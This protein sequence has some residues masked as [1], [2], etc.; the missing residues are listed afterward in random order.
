MKNIYPILIIFLCFVFLFNGK[1]YDDL[2]SSRLS[3]NIEICLEGESC[4]VAVATTSAS[5][6]TNSNQNRSVEDIYASG[7][8]T[9][10]DTGLAGSPLLGNIT[11]WSNRV[12]KGRDTL[13]NNA[14]NGINGM[15]AKGLCQDC[16][17]EEIA[18]V[19]DYMLDSI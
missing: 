14:W 4:G 12:P 11:Q 15:P 6:A 3:S 16:S 9:C 18:S 7:C 10:H 19:V 17:K 5:V 13:V 2:V 1:K 8:A